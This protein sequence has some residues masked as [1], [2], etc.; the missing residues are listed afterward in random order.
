MD[1]YVC[2]GGHQLWVPEG[3]VV[4][5]C[6]VWVNGQPCDGELVKRAKRGRPRKVRG[7]E[8]VERV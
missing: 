5:E 8:P 1:E 3:H 4:L 2:T 7:N 6:P